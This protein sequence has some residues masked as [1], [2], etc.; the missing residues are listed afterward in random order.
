MKTN[1]K[2]NLVFKVVY[3]V[4][5]TVGYT[6]AAIKESVISF[7]KAVGHMRPMQA[8]RRYE[9]RKQRKL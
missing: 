4:V 2:L 6:L 9:Q 3:V 5:Y 1:K 7:C 8:Q